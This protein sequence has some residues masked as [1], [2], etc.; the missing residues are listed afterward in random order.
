MSGPD[1]A[2]KPAGESIFQRI[3]RWLSERWNA[4][5]KWLNRTFSFGGRAGAGTARFMMWI[6]L[7]GLII[8]IAYV[9]AYAVRRVSWS[10]GGGTKRKPKVSVAAVELE[11]K[12][13]DPDALLAVARELAGS[14]QFRRAY[15]A[16]FLAILLR[17]DRQ[18][19]IRFER[20]R[21]NGEYLRSLRSRPD[22][23]NWMRPLTNDFDLR[24]YGGHSVEEL[25]YR[26]ALS[27]YER[28]TA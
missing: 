8:G 12:L 16:V 18:D 28:L 10:K 15:R 13:D 6:V 5:T 11:E 27:V 19:L 1:F 17:M 4:F 9:L 25:D 23:L 2:I 20:S 3:G 7:G 24:W 21:T 14:G 22:V 26:R